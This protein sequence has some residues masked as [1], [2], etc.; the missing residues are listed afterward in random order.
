[1]ATKKTIYRGDDEIV[2]LAL[3]STF[4]YTAPTVVYYV[5]NPATPNT[6]MFAKAGTMTLTAGVWTARVDLTQAETLIIPSGRL[7]HFFRV[8]EGATRDTFSPGELLMINA[9]ETVDLSGS[10]FAV[11]SDAAAV[12]AARNE[13]QAAAAAAALSAAQAFDGTAAVARAEA[14]KWA[15]QTDAEVIPGQGFGSKKYAM[16]ASASAAQTSLDRVATGGDRAQTGLDRV[17]TAAD[18][19]Q[20]GLDRASAIDAAASAAANRGAIDAAMATMAGMGATPSLPYLLDGLP[21]AAVFSA[22]T[23]AQVLSGA[24]VP[25]ASLLSFSSAQK[26]TVGPDGNYI[27]NA[28]N[29]PAFDWSTGRRRLLIEAVQAT[30]YWTNSENAG[31]WYF[32]NITATVS[33]NALFGRL[34][35]ATLTAVAS[36]MALTAPPQI[37]VTAGAVISYTIALLAGSVSSAAIGL[38]GDASAWGAAGYAS[39]TVVSGPGVVSQQAGGLWNVTGLSTTVPTVVTV[40]RTFTIAENAISYLYIGSNGVRAAGDSIK[41]GRPQVE[42]GSAS[43]YIPA[44]ASPTTRVGDV[45]SL[46]PALFALLKGA[47][48][49][50]IVRGTQRSAGGIVLSDNT[51][52]GPIVNAAGSACTVWS[53]G[54]MAFL[55]PVIAPASQ[56]FGVGYTTRMT[57]VSDVAGQRAV[58]ANGSAVATDAYAQI[59]ATS[60][61]ATLGAGTGGYQALNMLLDELIIWPTYATDAQLQTHARVYS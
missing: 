52:S 4:T 58:A 31:A 48:A 45:V 17:A 54:Q 3:P 47:N 21:P 11:S 43:S 57:G 24:T 34:A 44:G 23:G 28:A 37:A 22:P 1:M 2:S 41:V 46:S 12:L 8:S 26:Y 36:G 42:F 56:T 15:T 19:A 6:A 9:P 5:A 53:A 50:V 27:L 32:T 7:A 20:T 16:D 49:T 29:V 55:A 35:L 30:N 51:N 39:A 10:P 25:I 40:R 13:A 61:A 59:A 38:R 18:R 14:Q 33:A 60:T